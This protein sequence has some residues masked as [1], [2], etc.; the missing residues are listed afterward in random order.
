MGGVEADGR[1]PFRGLPWT[2]L[3]GATVIPQVCDA[4]PGVVTH[5]DLGVVRPHGLVRPRSADLG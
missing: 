3:L 1:R 4:K 5:I 2:A